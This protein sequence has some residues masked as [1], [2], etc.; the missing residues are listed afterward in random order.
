MI[1][2]GLIA[3]DWTAFCGLDTTTTEMAVR[4]ILLSL[5]FLTQYDTKVVENILNLKGKGS[6]ELISGLRSSLVD[7]LV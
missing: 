4:L 3:N 7:M 5:H 2:A 6:S 1:S